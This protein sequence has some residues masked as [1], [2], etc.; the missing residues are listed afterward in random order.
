MRNQEKDICTLRSFERNKYFYGKLLSVRDFEDEQSYLRGKDAIQ[1]RLIH[2]VGIVCGLKVTEESSN[3]KLKISSGVALD[4]CGREIV[5]SEPAFIGADRFNDGTNYLYLYY[6][7]CLNERVPCIV[8]ASTCEEKCDYSRSKETYDFSVSAD[9]GTISVSVKDSG[10]TAI[11]I[12]DAVVEMLQLDKAVNAYATIGTGTDDIDEKLTV[13]PG[14]YLVQ[15]SASGFEAE[16]EESEWSDFEVVTIDVD[17]DVLVDL[18]LKKVAESADPKSLEEL[19]LDHY[20]K[21]LGTCSQ[22]NDPNDAM[23]FIAVVNKAADGTISVVEAQTNN[24][25]IVVPNNPMLYKLLGI[26]IADSDNPHQTTAE[27]VKALKSI[28][29][30]GNVEDAETHVSNVNLVSPDN[31]VDIDPVAPE[32]DDPKINIKIIPADEDDIESVSTETDAGSSTRFAR[33]DHVHDLAPGVVTEDKIDTNAVTTDKIQATAV[34]GVKINA[35]AL[36]GAPGITLDKSTGNFLIGTTAVRRINGAVPAPADGK[37]SIVAGENIT[38]SDK[39]PDDNSLTISATGGTG[40]ETDLTTLEIDWS[41]GGTMTLGSFI[42]TV[43]GG[44]LRVKFIR[45]GTPSEVHLGN[46]PNEVF[47]VAVK[48]PLLYWDNMVKTYHY[49]YLPGD[50]GSEDGRTAASFRMDGPNINSY[51][52]YLEQIL[53]SESQLTILVQ[54]KCDFI[55]DESG[56]AV[57]GSHASKMQAS[58]LIWDDGNYVGGIRGGVFE[59]WFRII[60]SIDT[61][62][63]V[64]KEAFVTDDTN[65]YRNGDEIN[66]EVHTEPEA[67]VRMDLSALDTN[68][69]IP[70]QLTEGEEGVFKGGAVISG[71]NEAQNGDKQIGIT[72]MDAAGNVAQADLTVRLRNS[73]SGTVVDSSLPVIDVSGVGPSTNEALNSLG[74]ATVG[75]LANSAVDALRAGGISE[76]RASE[77]IAEAKRMLGTE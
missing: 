21:Y 18:S 61:T 31:T 62:P 33:G 72:A 25:R 63:P 47:L 41:H 7:E 64:V 40:L 23:V 24:Y 15:A 26:H 20:R 67:T 13:P 65:F 27:Q 77:I 68:K 3:T 73:L 36:M 49:E 2:G 42:S 52:N 74:I 35:G 30:V 45:A 53:R 43:T 39:D 71:D 10:E 60:P 12:E 6:D 17:E 34:T 76:S 4:C 46:T 11:D 57:D 59:S 56:K 37:I 48:T 19:T 75:D 51:L 54:L 70:V 5:L 1:N 29:N 50:V 69:A 8:N 55:R 14:R 66:I 44:G 28:N 38:I 16:M 32:N 22:C 58:G 9:K